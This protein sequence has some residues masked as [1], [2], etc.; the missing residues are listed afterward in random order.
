MAAS[1]PRPGPDSV[2]PARRKSGNA[3]SGHPAA[4]E[5]NR[6]CL[7]HP[8]V[9]H[10]PHPSAGLP[11]GTGRTSLPAPQPPDAA[12]RECAFPNGGCWL[13]CASRRRPSGPAS[14]DSF[15]GPAG[16]LGQTSPASRPHGASGTDRWSYG[17]WSVPKP[18][19]EN[20]AGSAGLPP[21]LG[22][23]G[24]ESTSHTAADPQ[25]REGGWP[26]DP[27]DRDTPFPST[28]S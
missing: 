11:V 7:P 24:F 15:C 25:S 5:A 21:E 27:N 17:R 8:S 28:T 9:P 12:P 2:P 22:C 13:E 6:R 3:A 26:A 16:L 18:A 10:P 20:P 19:T 23:C 4:R 14:P 1:H